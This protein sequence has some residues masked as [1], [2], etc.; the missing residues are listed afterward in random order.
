MRT[1][2]LVATLTACTGIETPDSQQ[3]PLLSSLPYGSTAGTN[4]NYA[5]DANTVILTFDDGPD[6]P[7]SDL[8]NPVMTM[9]IAYYLGAKQIHS[10]FFINGKRF[11]G[12][13][14]TSCPLEGRQGDPVYRQYDEWILDALVQLGHLLGNH[15]QDHCRLSL[16]PSYV[17]DELKLTQTILDRHAKDG[18]FLFRP[19]YGG[20]GVDING[21][22]D[23]SDENNARQDTCLDKLEGPIGW[24]IDGQDFDCWS[25]YDT[26]GNLTADSAGHPIPHL[27]VQQCLQRYVDILRNRPRKNGIF[28]HH[29]RPEDLV[30]VADYY[31][32][33]N[34]YAPMNVSIVEKDPQTGAQVTV[35]V[36]YG[37]FESNAYGLVR[38]EVEYLTARGYHFG[39]MEDIFSGKRVRNWSHCGDYSDSAGFGSAASKYR[40]IHLADVDGDGL[41]DACARGTSGIQCA[42]NQGGQLAQATSWFSGDFTDAYGW[43]PAQ[44]GA[45]VQFAD[46]DGDHRADVCGRG[47]SGMWCAVSNGSSFVNFRQASSDFSDG[48][49][50]A[51]A[52]SYYG[53]IHLA[54]VNHDN[55]PDLCARSSGGI[56]C[57]LNTSV[58]GTARFAPATLWMSSDFTDPGWTPAAYGATVQFGDIN[59]D[60]RA[61]VCGRGWYGMRCALAQAAGGFGPAS[62]WSQY[63]DFSDYDSNAD[64]WQSPGTYKSIRLV[65]VNGDHY[66]DVCARSKNGIVCA[67]SNGSS[68]FG[69]YALQTYLPVTTGGPTPATGTYYKDTDGFAPD[70]YGSTIQFGKL[71]GDT[72]PDVCARGPHGLHCGITQ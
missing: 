10:P 5:L 14:T 64:G 1:S 8:S 4:T 41:D 24:D 2:L 15:T 29:D 58:P 49:G 7:P 54:D 60:G 47:G 61:D 56:I 13:P 35:P 27:N 31:A 42:K 52:E 34:H 9:E 66:A 70:G 62:W 71:D 59:G 6:G 25:P 57:A 48:G 40:S 16:F 26:A 28:L 36:P 53:T 38:A 32:G 18:P 19:P 30:N 12:Q 22:L 65:D 55:L 44:Y 51:G 46:V 21:Q 11:T 63:P 68:A 69:H 37:P 20:W 33:T 45:T 43:N 17:D 72:R 39:R 50:W 23:P 3:S 67:L